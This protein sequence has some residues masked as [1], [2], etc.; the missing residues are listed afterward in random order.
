MDGAD[1]IKKRQ[2]DLRRTTRT[3]TKRGAKCIE[4]GCG[5]FEQLQ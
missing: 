3:I 1:L 4:V 2:D 5:I